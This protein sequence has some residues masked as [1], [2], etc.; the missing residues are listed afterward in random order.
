MKQLPNDWSEGD[1]E[2]GTGVQGHFCSVVREKLSRLRESFNFSRGYCAVTGLDL[3]RFS[4]IL[5]FGRYAPDEVASDLKLRTSNLRA[6]KTLPPF[7]Y[8]DGRVFM[9][10]YGLGE[11]FGFAVFESEMEPDELANLERSWIY[12]SD[13]IANENYTRRVYALTAPFQIGTEIGSDVRELE[14]AQTIAR[15]TALSFGA[16]AAVLRLLEERTEMLTP[17]GYVGDLPSELLQDRRPGEFISG[18][19]FAS[20]DHGWSIAELGEK[21]RVKG[22]PL[23]TEALDLLKDHGIQATFCAR[24]E[25]MIEDDRSKRIGT[26]SYYFLRPNFFSWRDA[27]L[28]LAFCGRAAD[29]IALTQQSERLRVRTNILEIQAPVM[30]QVELANLLVHDL[31]HKVADIEDTSKALIARFKEDISRHSKT[32]N[33]TTNEAITKFEESVGFLRRQVFD[34]RA[35]G[36]MQEHQNEAVKPKSFSVADTV[37]HVLKVMEG[38]LS[39]QKI[40]SKIDIKGKLEVYGPQKVL[41]HVILN[42]VMNTIDAARSRPSTRPMALHV[43]AYE[44]TTHVRIRVW[45][46]GPGINRSVF[47]EAQDIFKIGQSSKPS[48][49]GMGLPVA[50]T[51]LTRYFSADLDLTDARTARFE[52]AIRKVRRGG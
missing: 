39:R 19:V 23:P 49:T 31:S 42:L 45:D 7:S 11:L 40:E 15:V 26:L 36:R 14:L 41:E 2:S 35:V 16:D 12:L 17:A 3:Q 25:S 5:E 21:T 9:P 30:T 46:T 43:Q 51:L 22:H 47:Q 24:L 48:G 37:Q 27:M 50:R 28:F 29:T 32:I 1:V 6:S 44:D 33:P 13:Q 20:A 34:L 18:T 52:I 10:F 38:P 4:V 8:K